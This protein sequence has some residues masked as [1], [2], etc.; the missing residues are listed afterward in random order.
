MIEYYATRWKIESGFKELK[1]ETGALDNQGRNKNSVENC[2]EFCCLVVTLTRI[3]AI[4]QDRAPKKCF[5][6]VT[7]H[8]PFSDVREQIRKEYVEETNF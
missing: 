3:Y 1:Y 2:F 6:S 7:R 5:L 4:K 8:F